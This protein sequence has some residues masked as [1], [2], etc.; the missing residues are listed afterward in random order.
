VREYGVILLRH[1]LWRRRASLA[2]GAAVLAIS[3]LTGI[4]AG[5][6][7][8]L[9]DLAEPADTPARPAAAPAY[10][11]V[12]DMPAPRDT[13]PLSAEES[14]RIADELSALRA[15]QA[16]QTSGTAETGS[17]PDNKSPWPPW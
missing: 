6:T 14:K 4:L 11:A 8:Q 10:P 2:R 15:R 13:K 1:G 3:A 9:A 7:S 17:V 12:H 5:C 16:A